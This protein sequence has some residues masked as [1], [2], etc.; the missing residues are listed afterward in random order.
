[1]HVAYPM[2]LPLSAASPAIDAPAHCA[3]SSAL[4]AFLREVERRALKMAQLAV[5]NV[6][7]ALELVQEAMLGFV[8]RYAHK[9]ASDWKPLF[10][11]VLDSRIQDFH[12]RQNV[13]GRF[14]R[15]FKSDTDDDGPD[16]LAQVPDE[17]QHAPLELLA[18]SE[19][20]AALDAALR[21]LPGRQ[22]QAFLLRMWEGFDVAQTAAVMQC[23]E[24]SVK[25]HLFRALANLRTRLESHR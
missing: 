7:D 8:K 12:R 10:Y 6:D 25:T 19:A 18:G 4:D 17:S 21:A 16:S 20:G 22:R 23:S 15:W 1:M 5:R 2:P 11:A 14:F 24:G 3:H 13:R 9:P